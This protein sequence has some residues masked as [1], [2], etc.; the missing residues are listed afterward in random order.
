MNLFYRFLTF[1]ADSR[2]S[3]SDCDCI[4][5]VMGRALASIVLDRLFELRVAQIKHYAIVFAASPQSMHH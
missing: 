2:Y 5:R 1:F 4:D 3:L